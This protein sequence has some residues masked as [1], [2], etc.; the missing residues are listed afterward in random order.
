MPVKETSRTLVGQ[1]IRYWCMVLIKSVHAMYPMYTMFY[2]GDK[3]VCV[4]L[5][6]GAPKKQLNMEN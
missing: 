5:S 2:L 1:E 4:K 6:I 3:G